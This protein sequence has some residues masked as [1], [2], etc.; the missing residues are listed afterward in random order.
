MKKFISLLTCFAILVATSSI[1]LADHFVDG[2]SEIPFEDF[3][4]T[5]ELP[6]AWGYSALDEAT[7]AIY[8]EHDSKTIMLLHFEKYDSGDLHSALENIFLQTAVEKSVEGMI[9]ENQDGT[10]EMIE[11]TNGKPAAMAMDYGIDK[12]ALSLAVHEGDYAVILSYTSPHD[13]FE[14]SYAEDMDSIL[15]S[16]KGIDDAES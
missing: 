12:M 14:E 3:S 8:P 2:H 5:M 7:L 11:L 4:M 16:I 13:A 6:T 9:G 15:I 1:V 10:G